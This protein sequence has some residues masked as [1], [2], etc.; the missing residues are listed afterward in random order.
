MGMSG[1]ILLGKQDVILQGGLLL[2]GE[3]LV[4]RAEYFPLLLLQV[5]LLY[6]NELVHCGEEEFKLAGGGGDVGVKEL[7]DL[8]V[9]LVIKNVPLV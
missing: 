3:D 9:D 1:A 8:L 2:N 7:E 5:L 6:C 4:E